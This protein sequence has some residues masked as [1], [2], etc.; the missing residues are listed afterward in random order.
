MTK[1]NR[2]KVDVSGLQIDSM[3]NDENV[4]INNHEMVISD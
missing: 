3:P 4:K 1:F 2:L